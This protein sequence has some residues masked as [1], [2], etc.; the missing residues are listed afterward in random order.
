MFI[1]FYNNFVILLLSDCVKDDGTA[2][3]GTTK[4]TCAGT[5]NLCTAHGECLDCVKDDGTAGDGTTKGTCS[6]TN[7]LCTALGECLGT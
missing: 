7:N 6:G 4:G 1:G 2:G 5:N 3:D